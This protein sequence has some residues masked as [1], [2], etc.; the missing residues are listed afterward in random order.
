M[1]CARKGYSVADDVGAVRFNRPDMRRS[2]LRATAAVYQ[3]ESADGT[4]LGVGS[5]HNPTKNA[6][7][8][9]PRNHK[10][11][12]IA[13]LFELERRLL[14]PKTRRWEFRTNARERWL[15][16]IQAQGDDTIEIAWLDRTNGRLSTTGDS[17]LLVQHT[18]LNHARCAAERNGICEIEIAPGF[19]Q[20]EIHA[21]RRW[22]GNDSLNLRHGEIASRVG[23]L[24]RLI[25]DDPIANAGLNAAKILTGK[26]IVLGWTV[27]VDRV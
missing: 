3:L 20:S 17:S 1:H 14:V 9:D 24:A 15:A 8:H 13:A 10:T 18:L 21:G 19:D 23:H 11:R 4:A 26:L 25:V 12:S 16:F 2:D 27:F 6:V 5:Q 7:T 22:I